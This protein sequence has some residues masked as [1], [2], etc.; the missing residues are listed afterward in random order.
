M[1]VLSVS[2]LDTAAAFTDTANAA[3]SF[4]SAAKLWP[5]PAAAALVATTSRFPVRTLEFGCT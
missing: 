1:T 5:P 4:S 2:A 3:S